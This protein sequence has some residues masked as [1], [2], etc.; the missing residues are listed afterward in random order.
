[1]GDAL[2]QTVVRKVRAETSFFCC[3]FLFKES[4]N[5][6]CRGTRATRSQREECK[7]RRQGR[8]P[9][10]SGSGPLS[11]QRRPAWSVPFHGLHCIFDIPVCVR[12]RACACAYMCMCVRAHVRVHTCVR[13]SGRGHGARR[14]CWSIEHE[15]RAA[16]SGL[17]FSGPGLP[18]ALSQATSLPR[19]P[20]GPGARAPFSHA[21][22][23]VPPRCS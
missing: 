10:P 12:V 6:N 11:F 9:F 23:A 13:V 19:R 18:R 4:L 17:P 3:S 14:S 20:Q 1:M 8:C 2:S 15:R 21:P 7:H 22:P 16:V 5:F